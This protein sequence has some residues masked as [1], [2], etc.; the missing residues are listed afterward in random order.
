[1]RLRKFKIITG[2]YVDGRDRKEYGKGQIVEDV[3][4]LAT[5]FPGKFEEIHPH[6]EPA[7]EP[8]APKKPAG[9]F[10]SNVPPEPAK[11]PEEVKPEVDPFEAER[12]TPPAPK[13]PSVKV[14]SK[15][16]AGK[17]PV[18]GS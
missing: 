7:P 2:T 9:T 1:M 14:P 8:E 17:K 13:G 6:Y 18:N 12:Q 3:E 11:A 10:I 4:D 15:V 5:K 16:R